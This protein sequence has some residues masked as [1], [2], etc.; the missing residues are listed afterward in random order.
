MLRFQQ[1][2][3]QTD[4][5]IVVVHVMQ[6]HIDAT[7]VIGGGIDFLSEVFQ[8][9]ILLANSLGKL[10]QQRAGAAGRV[11]DLLD[12]GIIPRS[13]LRQQLRDLLGC[14]ELTTTLTRLRRI[15]LHQELVSVA[16][17]VIVSV[18]IL[19]TQFHLCHSL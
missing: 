15:H 3:F 10:Q 18:V 11:V 7:E 16:K 2:V 8:V 1:R 14:E 9:W 17:G 5:E 12:I 19:R 6:E 4:V 13:Q